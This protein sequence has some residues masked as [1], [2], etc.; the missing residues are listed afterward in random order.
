[1][2]VKQSEGQADAEG[3]LSLDTFKALE[4]ALPF[5]DSLI[6]NGIGE[7]LL[8][9]H[10]E[11]F[12]RRAKTFMPEGSWVG[13][14]SNGLLLDTHSA[15]SLLDAGLDRICLSLDAVSPD[16]FKKVRCGAEIRHLERTFSALSD[17]KSR[18]ARHDFQVGVEFVA[19]RNNVDELPATLRWAASHGATFAIVTQMLPYHQSLVSGVAYDINTDNA[20]SF[21]ERWRRKA[22]TE[23]VDI[24]HYF[25]VFMKYTKTDD[26][27]KVIK[28]IEAMVADAHA[29]GISLNIEQLLKRDEG[30]IEKVTRIFH[31]A[32]TTAEE[33]GLCLLLPEIIPK[34]GRKCDFVEE[35]GAFISWEGKVHPCYFL[36][37]RYDCFLGG[38]TKHVKPHVFGTLAEKDIL[39]IWND[40]SFRSFRENVLRYDFPFCYD[41]NVALCDYVQAAEFEQDCYISSVPCAACLWCTGLFQCLQ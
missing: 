5:L 21:L 29:H 24:Y 33:T 7:P 26:E 39:G 8:H 13:F 36:W 16:I 31:V 23:G 17:A 18:L 30:L 9:P 38:L 28:F 19:M 3:D 2:C 1:M 40:R 10:L 11:Y 34:G 35:G 25:D 4:P 15:S 6:L 14:Q 27:R 32:R 12:I 22:V 37:H 41:C 20:L